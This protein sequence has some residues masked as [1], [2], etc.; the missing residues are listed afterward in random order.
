[1]YFS[2][3]V[4][5]DIIISTSNLPTYVQVIEQNH[6]EKRTMASVFC[7]VIAHP[8]HSGRMKKKI[9]IIRESQTEE[10]N[11]ERL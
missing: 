2:Y 3:T 4:M 8:P 10:P 5:R 9:K 1:M 6:S 7:W 11:G